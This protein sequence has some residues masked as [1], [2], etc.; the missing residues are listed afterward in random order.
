M[1]PWQQLLSKDPKEGICLHAAACSPPSLAELLHRHEAVWSKGNCSAAVDL[2]IRRRRFYVHGMQHRNV[3]DV[4]T[5]CPGILCSARLIA[6]TLVFGASCLGKNKRLSA[7]LI[8]SATAIS[9]KCAQNVELNHSRSLEEGISWPGAACHGAFNP[10]IQTTLI[11]LVAQT[12]TCSIHL[13][14]T[15]IGWTSWCSTKTSFW[16]TFWRKLLTSS[17]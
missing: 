6:E 17:H 14:E 1:A 16:T 15:F 2:G 8:K 7:C 13:F 12:I 3:A 11:S 4:S 10:H 9:V 5:K